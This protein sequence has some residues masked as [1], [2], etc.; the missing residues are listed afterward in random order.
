MAAYDHPFP[1][2]QLKSMKKKSMKKIMLLAYDTKIDCLIVKG[3]QRA[4]RKVKMDFF[5]IFEEV[6][7]VCRSLKKVMKF[8]TQFIHR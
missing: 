2:N 8:S 4:L 1:F 5:V 6:A 3:S 7:T